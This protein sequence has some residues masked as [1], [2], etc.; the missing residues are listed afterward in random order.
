MPTYIL[1]YDKEVLLIHGNGVIL[2]MAKLEQNRCLTMFQEAIGSPVTKKKYLY[3]LNRFMK[4]NGLTNYDDLLKADEKSIQRNLEDYLIYL[5]GI[6]S[7]NY[8]PSMVSP[9]ELFYVMNDV[10]LN[11]K[12]LHK[13]FPRRIKKGGY[14]SYTREM[15]AQMIEATNKKRTKAILLFY[16]STGARVGVAPELQLQHIT[17][18]E[19]CK[20][21]VCYSGDK[22][23]Y[24]TFMTPEAA[25]AFDDY[26]EER[27]QDGEKLKPESPAFRK[28][29]LIASAPAESMQTGT[30]RNAVNVTLKNITK[31]K[32]GH[33][34]NIPMVHGLRKYFNVIMKSRHDCN[35]S[36]CEKLMGHSV[37][38]PM[39]NHYGTFSNEQI[40]GEYKKA[41]PELT[42]SDEERQKIQL[43]NKN[44]KLEELDKVKQEKQQQQKQI[45]ELQEQIN[46]LK[47]NEQ[48]SINDLQSNKGAL[49]LLLQKLLLEQEQKK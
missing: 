13:M 42:I 21:V 5:K 7:P 22:E 48:V 6:K 25:K 39:D 17:N 20:Q 4:W 40:F 2:N 45:D 35:L 16:S 18:I 46:T 10:N 32:T 47:L 49:I 29:Y 36:L 24:V 14:G 9:I 41:I 11:S 31:S 28:D 26:L 12:R 19:D 30:I 43:E 1:V 44:K 3:E 38:I 23:E 15:I 8:I 27:Q 37:T 33:N 34:Y